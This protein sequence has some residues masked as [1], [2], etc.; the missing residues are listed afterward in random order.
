MATPIFDQLKQLIRDEQPVA[1]A[2]VVEGERRGAKLLVQ[3]DESALGTLGNVDLD[4][5]VTRDALGE[6]A[7]GRSGIRHYGE[8]GEARAEGLSVFIE[9]YAPPP[10]M[11]IFGAVDFTAALV[12]VAKVLGYRVTVC[13]AREVFATRQRFPMADELVVDWPH[14]LLDEVGPTLGP[15]DAVAVLTHDAKFDVPAIQGA[16]ATNVGYIGVMGSR[17]THDDRTKRLIEV[18]LTSEDLDRLQS[19]IGLDLGART[20]EETAVSICAEVIAMRTGR[21]APSL[22]GT[23]GPIH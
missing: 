19:P 21:Q 5:V 10:Q 14:R 20:P 2:T 7:A 12:R 23:S 22:K 11:L 6:L 4:R 18:G 1:L 3:P 17:R 16:L 15:R 13:D 9:T 8:H